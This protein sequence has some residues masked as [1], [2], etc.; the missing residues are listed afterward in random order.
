MA[1]FKIKRVVWETYEVEAA[2]KEEALDNATDPSSVVVVRTTIT[3]V[4]EKQ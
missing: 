4:K 1:Y 3:P 2:T